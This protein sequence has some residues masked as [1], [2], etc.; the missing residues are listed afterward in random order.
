MRKLDQYRFSIKLDETDADHRKVA[1]YLNQFGRK[2][3]RII[4]K[5]LLLYMEVEKG[6]VAV[7][8]K[9]LPR[10][11]TAETEKVQEEPDRML[12]LELGDYT[13]DQAE[14]ELMRRNYAKLGDLG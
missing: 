11:E 3:A 4:V 7:E 10:Q 9:A 12:T 2:K 8:D 5:A 6:S 1:D 13:M 14:I